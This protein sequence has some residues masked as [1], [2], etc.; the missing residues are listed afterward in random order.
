MPPPPKDYWFHLKYWGIIIPIAFLVPFIYNSI[1][2]LGIFKE[3]K[4]YNIETCQK[5]LGPPGLDH[6]ED[7][8][9]SNEPGV[10]YVSCDPML[11][12]RNKVMGFNRLKPGEPI[13]NGAIWRVAYDQ[14]PAVIEKLGSGSLKSY[15]PLGISFDVHPVTGEKTI[16]TINLADNEPPSIEVFTVDD[17][18]QLVHKHTIRHQKIYNPNHVH[19]I[20][21]EQFRADDGTPSF[22]FSNDHYFN[23]PLLKHIETYFL[24]WS[25]VGFYNARTRQVEKAVDGLLFANGVAGTDDVLFVAE[26]SAGVVR[27]YKI[28]RKTDIEGVPHISLDYLNKIKV[29][30]V[31]DNLHYHPDKEML[32]IALHP[33]PTEFYKRIAAVDPATAP[34]ASSGV[35]VWD[36]ST[37]ETKLILQDDGSLFSTSSGAVFD[38]KNSKLI[39]SG[40]YD[41]GLLVCDL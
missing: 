27:Q 12:Y 20:Q 39:V 16:F 35:E 29:S 36:V 24:P 15:H 2:I 13:E 28:N 9:L 41:H 21:S 6:C 26:T 14:K 1:E 37:G 25:N 22:F 38:T 19:V 11:A 3:I 17:V 23:I 7:I 32:V 33:K 4:S 8:T 34:Y 5:L 18:K 40:I 10:A 31:P 30:G